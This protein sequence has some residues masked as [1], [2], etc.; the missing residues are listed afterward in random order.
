[1]RFRRAQ[2]G[3]GFLLGV[4]ALVELALRDGALVPEAFRALALAF[5]VGEPRLRRYHLG[6]RAVD[7]RCIGVG[8]DGDQEV[9]L[10]YQRALHEVHRLD[11]AGDP[12]AHVDALD[13]LEAA[14]ELVPG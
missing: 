9:V 3:V 13:R 6:L 4:H 10:L 11:G 8:I 7:L 1:R 5:R 2:V 14:G 12:R